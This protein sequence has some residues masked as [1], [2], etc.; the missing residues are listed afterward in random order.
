MDSRDTLAKGADRRSSGA[1]FAR[2]PLVVIGLL[3]LVAGGFVAREMTA[4]PAFAAEPTVV[5]AGPA[6]PTLAASAAPPVVAPSVATRPADGTAPPSAPAKAGDPIV[7]LD[8]RPTPPPDA[9][10]V[11]PAA[12][13]TSSSGGFMRIVMMMTILGGGALAWFLLR[14]RQGRVGPSASNSLS[15]MGSVRVAGRWQVALVKVPGKTL[16]LG[17]TEKGLTLLSELDED[18]LLETAADEP[19]AATGGMRQRQPTDADELLARV[20]DDDSLSIG[21]AANPRTSGDRVPTQRGHGANPTT[22]ATR[23]GAGSDPF[24]RLLDQLT[25]GDTRTSRTA[26]TQIGPE[27]RP[28]LRPSGAIARYPADRPA[29]A[30]NPQTY[31]GALGPRTSGERMK[32]PEAQALRARLERH[33]APN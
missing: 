11:A 31:M 19:D 29:T 25:R 14:R 13:V 12:P 5:A 33:Q 27:L 6:T 1:S 4:A 2:P 24:G 23:S 26:D 8:S 16:V 22:D 9:T 7:F 10:A 15:L 17:A 21:S 32:T 20:R 18:A 30:P 28:E 3:G